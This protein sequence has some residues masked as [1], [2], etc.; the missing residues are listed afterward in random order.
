MNTIELF[1]TVVFKKKLNHDLNK[2]IKFSNKVKEQKGRVMSNVGGYQSENLDP[3]NL[4]IKNLIKEISINVNLFSKETLNIHKDINLNDIWLNINNHKDFNTIHNHPFSIIS[5]I[6][7]IKTPNN[8]G[9]LD[10]H[11]SS[12]SQCFIND[13]ILKQYNNY[14][15]SKWYFPV[16]ENELY[17]F[18]SWLEHSV[19][20]NLSNEERISFSFNF[21]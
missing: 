6:F 4:S 10:F 9:G 16:E 19:R 1:K 3:S 2:L 11:N 12:Q 21:R 13:D 17:L 20:P 8:C 18:P 15:S 14:N 5:G 7:Y